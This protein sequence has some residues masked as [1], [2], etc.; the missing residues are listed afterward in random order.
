[1]WQDIYGAICLSGLEG[2]NLIQSVLVKVVRKVTIS[3]A[4]LTHEVLMYNPSSVI[5]LANPKF[6]TFATLFGSIKTFL[7]ARSR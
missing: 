6:P 5:S 1:M 3:G 4:I 2:K 7:A